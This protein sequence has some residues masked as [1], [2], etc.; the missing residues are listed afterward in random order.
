[1]TM[2]F[3]CISEWRWCHDSLSD[4]VWSTGGVSVLVR[5]AEVYVSVKCAVST[6]WHRSSQVAVTRCSSLIPLT[7][8][9][10][11]R[12]QQTTTN[13]YLQVPF[14]YTTLRLFTLFPSFQTHLQASVTRE[15]S[16]FSTHTNVPLLYGVRTRSSKLHA[17]P[18]FW[19]NNAAD[20][21]KLI[22]INNSQTIL[23]DVNRWPANL[24][25]YCDGCHLAPRNMSS[26][27]IRYR[28]IEAHSSCVSCVFIYFHLLKLSVHFYVD[29]KQ[30]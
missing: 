4:S 6:W 24:S 2:E 23:D 12:A 7:T 19:L 13:I 5:V 26:Y 14:I 28:R 20:I 10:A 18:N 30:S 1:M 15:Y 9:T 27:Q 3:S 17:P 8:A 11:T 16:C 25:G 22:L 29:N 21:Y